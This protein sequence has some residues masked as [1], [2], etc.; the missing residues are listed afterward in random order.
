MTGGSGKGKGE[1]VKVPSFGVHVVSD[2]FLGHG[3]IVRI[4]FFV[5][6][7]VNAPFSDDVSSSDCMVINQSLRLCASLDQ[8]C[9]TWFCN[10][11]EGNH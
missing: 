1:G 2:C 11:E 6:R 9:R 8:V 7:E 3:C 4:S 5:Q 10:H